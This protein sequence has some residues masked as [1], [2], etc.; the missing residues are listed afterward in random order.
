MRRA[1]VNLYTIEELEGTAYERALDCLREIN[2]S[3]IWWAEG[4]WW[5]GPFEDL[6]LKI[7]GDS[8]YFDLDRGAW[9]CPNVVYLWFDRNEDMGRAWGLPALSESELDELE[10]DVKIEWQDGNYAKLVATCDNLDW[11]E[12][13]QAKCD[14]LCW[15]LLREL[16]EEYD[17]QSSEEALTDFADANDYLFLEN[18]K[19]WWGDKG[20]EVN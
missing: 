2:L 8:P 19:I 18:G 9:A 13:M 1:T 10:A 12:R 5:K 20:E 14:E 6:G 16:R 15:N 11:Q 7:D 3:D 17:Y 4:D